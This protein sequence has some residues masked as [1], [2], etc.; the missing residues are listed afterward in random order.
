MSRPPFS[1]IDF[2]LY[3]SL[4]AKDVLRTLEKPSGIGQMAAVG[5]LLRRFLS[6][7]DRK[8]FDNMSLSQFLRLMNEYMEMSSVMGEIQ[9]E[10]YVSSRKESNGFD[11]ESDD[12]D[13]TY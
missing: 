9:R 2:P 5:R 13:D 3:D 4:P 1:A 7:E 11:I 12:G 8:K 10:R 6:R